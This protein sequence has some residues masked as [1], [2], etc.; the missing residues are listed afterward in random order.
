SQRLPSSAVRRGYVDAL[1]G[2]IKPGNF[3]KA[4]ISSVVLLEPEK[5][6]YAY[7]V[8][9][10]PK[11]SWGDWAYLGVSFTDGK[12]LGATAND[13]RCRDKR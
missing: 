13:D 9:V 7:C 5:K 11:R 3:V 4:E 6:T 12:I 2:T 10:V 8:R 1:R